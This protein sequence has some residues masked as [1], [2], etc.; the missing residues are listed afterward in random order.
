VDAER[1][2][3]LGPARGASAREQRP[4]E[5][6]G[7]RTEMAWS[8]WGDP[9]AARALS[10]ELAELA[11]QAL[12]ITRPRPALAREQLRLPPAR[13]P[14]SAAGALSAVLGAEH[15]RS[16]EHERLLHVRGK[17]TPDLLRTRAGDLEGAPDAVLTPGSHEEVLALLRICS[18][19]RIAAVPF[20]GGT[21]VVGGLEPERTGF[22][23]VVAIDVRRLDRLL[24]LDELSRTAT[25]EPGLRGPEAESLLQARG[26]TIGHHPQSFQYATLGGFAATRSSGQASAGYGRFDERVLGLRLATPRGTLEAGRAPRSA[27][28][29]DLRQLILGSEGALGVITGLRIQLAPAPLARRYEGWRFPSFADGLDAMRR[30]AQDGPRASVLRLSDEAE[31]ALGLA[32]PDAMGDS[33]GG[34]SLAIVGFEGAEEEVDRRA[35]AASAILRALGAVPVPGAGEE[36]AAGRY[37]APYLRDA[38]LDAGA[39]V[40]TLETAAFWSALPGLHRHLSE[41][42][43]RALAEQGSPPLVLCHLSHVYVAG[44]SLYYTVAAAAL[45]DPI[46]QW[47]R[48]KRAA[49]DA[50]LA[51]GGTISHH[52]GVG[53]DHREH[54]AREIGELG[55]ELL[56]A[57]KATL[58]PAGILNPGVLLR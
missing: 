3:V 50:I 4:A 52:H 11:R 42:L 55:V 39:L 49:S 12:G 30:L 46:A 53:R 35:R 20:G 5:P 6:E 58:D 10:P 14:D 32:R 22:Q 19:R 29:P 38:L 16:G 9:A 26:Y 47:A 34:G 48:A 1:E 36:W 41:A 40:E 44:A 2:A 24:E 56:G 15:V 28:G 57:V 33:H 45:E 43:R 17:S 18:E 8:G 25:L 37:Q 23:A 7:G 13:L 54:Y 31:S 21:S 51:A 27:A